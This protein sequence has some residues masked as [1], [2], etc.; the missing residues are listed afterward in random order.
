MSCILVSVICIRRRGPLQRQVTETR[1]SPRRWR[2]WR[3]RAPSGTNR[4]VSY[5]SVRN[6]YI[7]REGQAAQ[8]SPLIITVIFFVAEKKT[9]KQKNEGIHG[10]FW[11]YRCE[12]TGTHEFFRR[13]RPI[14]KV[15]T[16]CLIP[17]MDKT[18]PEGLRL[19]CT[20]LSIY[21]GEAPS[22]HLPA[23]FL[24]GPPSSVLLVCVFFSF[25]PSGN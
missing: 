22:F 12:V 7:N 23:A 9:E 4:A 10:T 15:W 1:S 13:G 5:L 16:K 2:G 20:R 18:L 11:K 25:S 19:V 21:S 17:L 8:P 3:W 6:H 14:R 24:S